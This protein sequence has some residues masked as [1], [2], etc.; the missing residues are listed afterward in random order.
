MAALL[1]VVVPGAFQA[2]GQPIGIGGVVDRGV[3][4]DRVTLRVTNQTGF[5]FR[6]ELDG[7]PIPVGELVVVATPDYHE[8]WVVRTND[9]SLA[10]EASLVRFIVTAGERGTSERGIP[11]HVPAPFIPSAADEFGGGELRL[12]VPPSFPAGYEIP[13]VAWVADAEHQPV[14]A[15]GWLVAEGLPAIAVKRGVGSGFLPAAASGPVAYAPS[16]LNQIRA[17]GPGTIAIE[18]NVVWTSVAGELNGAVTWP[19]NARIHVTGSLTIP[20]GASL[21]VG[22]GAVVRLGARVDITNHG[23]I[24]INGTRERPVVF[25]PNA[26]T[27]PW[28]GFV[29]KSGAGTIHATG[30]IF[31][32]SGAEPGWF[33]ANG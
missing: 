16:I 23:T 6:A 31:T 10:V 19:T 21:V 29:M 18:T 14:R 11:P 17:S 4:T 2:V 9:A 3:Y 5:S 25:M 8:L 26:P 13:V 15:N 33:G 28:G 7:Q 20:A 24:T 27:Q 12:M 1:L 30:T 22:A 32:G